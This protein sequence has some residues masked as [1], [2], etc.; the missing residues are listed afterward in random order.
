MCSSFTWGTVSVHFLLGLPLAYALR[1]ATPN[2]LMLFLPPPPFQD[3]CPE[4]DKVL[5]GC[6]PGADIWLH[7]GFVSHPLC[8]ALH[9]T[10]YADSSD[11]LVLP[12]TADFPMCLEGRPEDQPL[13]GLQRSGL[14]KSGRLG[15]TFI[16]S[17]STKPNALC[18]VSNINAQK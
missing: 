14:S 4:G 18:N 2:G 5:Q 6:F 11:S 12:I 10:S 15:S 9:C 16:P 7:S 1:S 13:R 3:A 17:Q 8:T